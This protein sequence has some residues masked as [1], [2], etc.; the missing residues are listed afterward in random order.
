M[1]SNVITGLTCSDILL[2][3]DLKEAALLAGAGGLGRYINRVNVMEVPDVIDWVRPGEF[4][5]T[6]GFL[7]I[8]G[9]S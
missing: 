9:R 7:F 6:S 2:I 5:I 1:G 4:L 3:P 8:T